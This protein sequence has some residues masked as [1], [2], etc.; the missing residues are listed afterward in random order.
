M[1]LRYLLSFC[2]AAILTFPVMQA[3]AQ[4]TRSKTS[5]T[6]SKTATSEQVNQEKTKKC[7]WSS[8]SYTSCAKYRQTRCGDKREDA[9]KAA[10]PA[11]TL[12]ALGAWNNDNN[13]NNFTTGL[14][15]SKKI[16]YHLGVGLLS[17]VTFNEDMQLRFGVPV[18]LNVNRNIRVS[19]APLLNMQQT[20]T[21]SQTTSFD[22]LPE[23]TTEWDTNAGARLG[24]SYLINANGFIIAP[25]ARVDLISN[26]LLPSVGIQMGLGL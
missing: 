11:T 10:M 23:E 25:T 7:D 24:F 14:E 19:A 21:L 8:R 6:K 22:N 13:A 2:L 20:T 9:I 17:E 1:K 18:H 4:C 15:F 5:C 26:E 12:L 3:E 16:N